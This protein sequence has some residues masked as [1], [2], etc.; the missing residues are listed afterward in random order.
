MDDE[1]IAG[2]MLLG[3]DAIAA[4]LGFTRRQVYDLT[5][6]RIMPSFKIGKTVAAR[7]STLRAWIEEL[8]RRAPS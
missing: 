2:D 1:P 6:R 4:F 3:A 7:K 8:E 5:A